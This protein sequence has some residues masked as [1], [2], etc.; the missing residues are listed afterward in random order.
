MCTDLA[1]LFLVPD[2]FKDWKRAKQ[3]VFMCIQRKKILDPEG[4]QAW[5]KRSG[6]R[7]KMT[8]RRKAVLRLKEQINELQDEIKKQ[9]VN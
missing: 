6:L 5:V 8:D 2:D 1:G 3:I 4:Y 9:K 7:S